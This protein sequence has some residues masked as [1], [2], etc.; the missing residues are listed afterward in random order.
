MS[1]VGVLIQQRLIEG[2]HLARPGIIGRF[3]VGGVGKVGVVVFR[4]DGDLY[5]VMLGG[6]QIAGV[7]H[8]GNIARVSTIGH[9]VCVVIAIS[10]GFLSKSH[11]RVIRQ[12]TM[13]QLPS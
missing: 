5:V 4:G 3:P 7:Q 9:I 2:G 6:A 13:D 10:I 8:S 11:T 1:R 12:N